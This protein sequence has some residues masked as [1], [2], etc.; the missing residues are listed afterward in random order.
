MGK[1]VTQIEPEAM[2]V[3][4]S[5]DWPGNVRE[6][7]SVLKQSMINATA[8]VITTACLPD[9]RCSTSSDGAGCSLLADHD[10]PREVEMKG[11][12]RSDLAAFIEERIAAGT[13]DLHAETVEMMERHLLTRVLR[14]TDGNQSNAAKLLGVTRGSLRNKLRAL[15]LSIDHVIAISTDERAAAAQT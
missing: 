2:E 1:N 4:L 14:E 13:R 10:L 6:L 3:L 7:Q 9:V 8:T 5:Y 11:F 12:P 15:R